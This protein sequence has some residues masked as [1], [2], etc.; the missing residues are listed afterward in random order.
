M[1]EWLEGLQKSAKRTMPGAATEE[2]RRAETECGVPFPEELGELYRRFNGGELQGDVKLFPLYGPEGEPS[3]LEKTRLKLESLPAAG[4]WRIG[5]EG[6]HRQLFSARKS[7]MVEQADSPLPDWAEQLSDDDWLYGTWETE[8][9]ELRLYRS[10]R[11]M[12]EVLVPPAEVEERGDGTDTPALSEEPGASSDLSV[13][14]EEGEAPPMDEETGEEERA[15]AP[16]PTREELRSLVVAAAE[17]RVE[18]LR[19]TAAEEVVMPVARATNV[20]KKAASGARRAAKKAVAAVKDVAQTVV[21]E[22]ARSVT[23]TRNAEKTAPALKAPAAKK[24]PAKKAPTRKAPA[25]KAPAKKAAAK[26]EAA[27][28]APARKAPAAKKEA[29]K[30]APARK[31]PA[32]K[33]AEK[34]AP[35]RRA[36][37]KKAAAKKAP[38]KK[39]AEKKAA[40]KKAPARRAPA[41]KAPARKATGTRAAGGAARGRR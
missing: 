21:V 9:R 19:Q 28:K 26:K 7:A 35:A 20:A 18:R 40:A 14:Y 41:K 5:V 31:A 22:A 39:A 38:A 24:V 15:D 27:K 6:A 2:I 25:K 3:V 36:P 8:A 17:R 30:K 32:K 37:A 1:H 11:D 34:K 29:A 13:E 23:D 16:E 33:A 12:L 10:L 4:V